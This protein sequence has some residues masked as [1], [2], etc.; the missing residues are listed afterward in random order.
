MKF[1]LPGATDENHG[2]EMYKHIREAVSYQTRFDLSPRKIFKLDYRHNGKNYHA[3]VDK[4]DGRSGEKIIAILYDEIRDLYYI[5]TLH[6]GLTGMPI[7]AGGH[8]VED[9]T[10]FD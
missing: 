8:T 10:D 9:Y 6:N 3:E 4:L 1:F 5:C 7:F 2:L